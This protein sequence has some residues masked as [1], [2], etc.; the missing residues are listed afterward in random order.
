MLKFAE[1]DKS[2]IIIVKTIIPIKILDMVEFSNDVDP[3]IFKNGVITVQPEKQNLFNKAI[4]NIEFL[5]RIDELN[6]I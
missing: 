4:I 5:E 3:N 6:G 2:K 1:T